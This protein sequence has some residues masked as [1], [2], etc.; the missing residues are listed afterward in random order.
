M[1]NTLS[2]LKGGM[3]R[4]TVDLIIT[5]QSIYERYVGLARALGN[6]EI[7]P[8]V[9]KTRQ[10]NLGMGD[11]MFKNAEMYYDP[12]CPDEHMYFLNTDTL[13]FCYD[14]DYWMMMTEWKSEATTLERYAQVVS[15]CN[16]ICNNFNKNGV[17]YNVKGN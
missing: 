16:L 6:Y 9:A 15:C 4:R 14:P 11:A 7:N 17:M 12:D 8:A 1:Y 3:A 13:E 5:T 2:N 10:V